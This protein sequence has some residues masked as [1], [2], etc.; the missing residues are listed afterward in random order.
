MNILAIAYA[1]EPNRGSEP[2]VGWN[3][4]KLIANHPDVKITVVTRANNK[5]VIDK[6]LEEKV[7]MKAEFLYYDLP[8]SVLKYKHGDRGIKLFFTLWQKGVI[9]YLKKNVNLD[10]YDVVWDFNFGSLNLPLYTYKLKKRYVVGP[11]STK[12]KMPKSYIHELS[13]KAKMKYLLQ[14]ILKEH[15]FLNPVVWKA[16]KKSDRV[17]LCNEMSREF[18]PKTKQAGAEVV[19]HNGLVSEDYPKIALEKHSEKL[20][21]IYSGRLIDTKNLETAIEALKIVKEAGKDFSLDIFG[22]GPLKEKLQRMVKTYGLEQE[23]VFH[24]KVTQME[25]FEE[26]TKRDIYLF[27][28]LLEISSTSVMEA[29][30]CGLLPICLEIRCMDFIFKDSPIV[31]VPCISPKEDAKALAEAMLALTPE[32][33]FQKRKESRKKAEESFLWETREATVKELLER[34]RE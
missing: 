33:I 2:G 7:D 19:F 27:P 32:G 13:T 12:K 25:L 23:I 5:P 4:V 10:D 24:Q 21:M 18:L 3:W 14:Q 22:K 28:S 11:A 8:Q 15:L 29:M 31:K 17:V 1:C 26:Y 9:K 16:L 30:Y 6:Y 34:I 20:E